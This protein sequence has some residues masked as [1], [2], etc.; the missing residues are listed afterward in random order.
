MMRPR[1]LVILGTTRQGRQGEH[2]ARW[3]M[4]RLARRADAEFEMVDLRDHPLPFFDHPVPPTSGQYGPEAQ[5]WAQVIARGD[6]YI[7]VTPEYNH[8]YPAV[9]KNALDHVYREWNR[10]P[11]AFVSYGA[12]AGG[13]RAAEQ[14]R[15]VAIELQLMPIR[16][17]VGIPFP[18]MAFDDAGEP[19]QSGVDRALDGMVDDL[20]WWAHA[21]MAERAA[22]LRANNWEDM[23]KPLP[24]P[25]GR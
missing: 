19:R 16:E 13:F 14:L 9:L 11:V 8:G 21:L 1:I 18:W 2:V 5:R 24:S 12:A 20:L 17:Q 10:K 3:L 4:T 6:G 22:D 25:V 7:V 15:Q 23:P